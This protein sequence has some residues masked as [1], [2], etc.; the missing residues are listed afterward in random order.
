VALFITFEGGEGTGKT[1]HVGMLVDRLRAE[2]HSAVALREPGGT[3]LGD[4]LRVW[5]KAEDRPMTPEA[6]LLLFAAARAELVRTVVRPALEAGT[7][8]VLDR[9]ADS[10]TVYQGYGRGLPMTQVRAANKLAMDGLSPD[11]TLLL[12]GALDQTLGRALARTPG[13]LDDGGRRF[14]DEDFTFHRRVRAG[15]RRLAKR[16]LNRWVRLDTTAPL[17]D[18]HRRIWEAVVRSLGVAEL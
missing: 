5:L 14:E 16:D 10:T 1:T 4:Y 13:Q 6:E 8:V 3:P 15:F 12:E 18:V 2:G 9:Y 17:S 7:H 11:L